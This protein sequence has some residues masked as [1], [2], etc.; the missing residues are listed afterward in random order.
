M[1]SRAGSGRSLRPARRRPPARRGRR[2]GTQLRDVAFARVLVVS[3]PQELGSVPDPP[4]G[5]VIEGHLHDQFRAKA[6][7]DQLLVGLPAA[8]LA[9]AAL[10][11]PVRL[12]LVEQ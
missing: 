11:G 3:P 6:L 4:A 5:Y 1:G 10:V 12:E 8:R 7:P 2:S 9:R